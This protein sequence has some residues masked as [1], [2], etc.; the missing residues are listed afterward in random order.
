[1]SDMIEYPDQDDFALMADDPEVRQELELIAAEF[2]CSES[3]GLI[4][5]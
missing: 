1:M 2:A 5:T 3:D 4:E